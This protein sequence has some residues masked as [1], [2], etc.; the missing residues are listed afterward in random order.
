M[1]LDSGLVAVGF[2]SI[3]DCIGVDRAVLKLDTVGDTLHIL[4]GDILVSPYVIDFLLHI[5]GMCKL[6]GK[7]T[8]V[9]KQQHTC[10]VAVKTPYRVDAF[11]ACTLHE[12]EHGCAAV[13]VVGGGD[14]VFRLVKK[15][16]A[17]AFECNNLFIVFHSIVVRNLCTEFGHYLP[18]DLHQTLLDEFVGFTT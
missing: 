15:D 17:L 16:I 2:R 14:A 13:G 9:G 6:R 4:F 8:V 5:F 10:G 12:V 1:N 11:I 18:V 7:V 3:G